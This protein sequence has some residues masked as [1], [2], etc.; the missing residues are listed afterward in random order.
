MNYKMTF[1][2]TDNLIINV[3]HLKTLP[4]LWMP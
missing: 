3:Y 1:D 4:L 2:Y